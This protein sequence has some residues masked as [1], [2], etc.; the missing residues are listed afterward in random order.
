MNSN[1]KSVLFTG[2]P[3][4]KAD[5]VIECTRRTRESLEVV[6]VSASFASS[7]PSK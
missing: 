5:G 1:L 6:T 7:E 4:C 3:C 2:R